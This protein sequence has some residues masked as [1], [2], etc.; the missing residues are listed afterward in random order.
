MGFRISLQGSNPEPLMSALGQKRTSIR[1]PQ[2]WSVEELDSVY[3][4][5]TANSSILVR[6]SLGISCGV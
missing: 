2:L 1:F 4:Y 3:P 5:R 6:S